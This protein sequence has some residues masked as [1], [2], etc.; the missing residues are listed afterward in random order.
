MMKGV[1]FFL[2]GI[3]GRVFGWHGYNTRLVLGSIMRMIAIGMQYACLYLQF[4]R[5]KQVYS[6]FS[7][8]GIL[9][10]FLS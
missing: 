7:M 2:G 6:D 5:G 4:V 1:D 8:E 10:A 3:F 9:K